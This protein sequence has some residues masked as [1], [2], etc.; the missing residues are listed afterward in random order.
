MEMANCLRCKKVFPK[1]IDPI[2]DEC[3]KKDEELFAAVRRYLEENPSSTVQRLSEETGASAK[4]ILA[5]L[6]E[7]RLE[8]AQA[9]GDLRCGHCG[10]SIA[11]GRFCEACFIELSRQIDGITGRKPAEKEN[12][13]SKKGV[14]MH[15]KN[16]KS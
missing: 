13:P 12:A 10:E 2:C 5:W 15:T 8:I 16:R 7:G 9:T 4:K 3:K 14:V 11:T 6:R 1:I